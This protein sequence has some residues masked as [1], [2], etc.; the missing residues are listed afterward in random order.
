M[1]QFPEFALPCL[2]IQQGMTPKGRVSPFRD[3]RIKA[4]CQLPV[5]FRRL[6]R[7]SSPVIAKASTTC[8]YSLDPITLSP[9]SCNQGVISVSHFNFYFHRI[10]LR[11]RLSQRFVTDLQW[12]TINQLDTIKTHCFSCIRFHRFPHV[13]VCVNHFLYF[14]QIFKELHTLNGES[15]TLNLPGPSCS[16]HNSFVFSCHQPDW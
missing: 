5:A 15:Y 16:F 3:L 9:Q 2:C 8:T 1:F 13:H 10:D 14:F 6:T 12:L 11:I 7:L 4:F